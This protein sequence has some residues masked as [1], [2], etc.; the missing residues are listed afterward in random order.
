MEE[1]K[2]EKTTKTN[3][4]IMPPARLVRKAL[5]WNAKR[6]RKCRACGAMRNAETTERCPVCYPLSYAKRLPYR[7]A[8][9]VDR[10]IDSDR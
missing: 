2:E 9:P 1:N 4:M 3:L 7:T 5:K 8:P 6:Y 10:K